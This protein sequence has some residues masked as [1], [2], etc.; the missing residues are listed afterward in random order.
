MFTHP[1]DL[2]RTDPYGAEMIRTSLH[3]QRCRHSSIFQETFFRQTFH[4]MQVSAKVRLQTFRDLSSKSTDAIVGLCNRQVSK[5]V[6]ANISN[7]SMFPNEQI[8]F[9]LDIFHLL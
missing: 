9:F 2:Q 6:A 7:I 1:I 8:F 3:Q 4:Q 5:K